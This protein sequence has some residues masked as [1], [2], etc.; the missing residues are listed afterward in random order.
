M[1]KLILVYCK[2]SLKILCMKGLRIN[3]KPGQII[4]AVVM[5]VF[6]L[7]KSRIRSRNAAEVYCVVCCSAEGRLGVRQALRGET[8]TRQ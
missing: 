2:M 4:V 1:M 5:L 6:T 7:G 8:T 3:V